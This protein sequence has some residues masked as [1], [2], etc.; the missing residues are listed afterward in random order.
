MRE[1]WSSSKSKP[2]TL[3]HSSNTP[4]PMTQPLAVKLCVCV[5]AS[6]KSASVTLCVLQS[7]LNMFVFLCYLFMCVSVKLA[8]CLVVW[9][10]P[11]WFRSWS[12]FCESVCRVYLAKKYR[13]CVCRFTSTKWSEG[14]SSENEAVNWPPLTSDQRQLW[15]NSYNVVYLEHFVSVMEGLWMLAVVVC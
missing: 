8:D 11:S 9:V 7:C 2:V 1:A 13:Y 14:S 3:I 6:L 4:N 15:D 5:S 10:C 12:S